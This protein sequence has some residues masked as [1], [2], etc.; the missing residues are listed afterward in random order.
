MHITSLD[1]CILY[2]LSLDA[3][4]I[5]PYFVYDYDQ[6][7][8]ICDTLSARVFSIWY[9]YVLDDSTPGKVLEEVL[10]NLY[11]IIDQSLS[12]LD[13]SAYM[14]LCMYEPMCLSL[15][16][17]R[18]EDIKKAGEFLQWIKGEFEEAG[19]KYI[20]Q[21]LRYLETT[22]LTCKHLAEMH[23]LFHHWGHPTV[24]EDVAYGKTQV[25]G[26][27]RTV[28]K[29]S[30][31]KKMVVLLLSFLNIHGRPPK[32]KIIQFFRNKPIYKLLLTG[33]LI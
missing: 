8:M 10:L 13:N 26:Q 11:Q 19:R 16:L 24:H 6:I 15:M 20:K 1:V 29:L 3:D 23:G 2:I 17:D 14:A 7:M 32:I 30:T 21:A 31:Q 18:F 33:S 28:P 9:N 22:E 12:H 5:P 27:T 25:T 4:G